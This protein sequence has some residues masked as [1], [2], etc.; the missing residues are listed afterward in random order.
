MEV[1]IIP[2]KQNQEFEFS[3]FQ[4]RLAKFLLNFYSSVKSINLQE[5]EVI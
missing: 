1:N 5:M 4:N 2:Y 3:S